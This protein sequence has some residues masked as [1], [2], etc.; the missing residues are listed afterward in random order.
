MAKERGAF[1]QLLI[2]ITLKTLACCRTYMT[3]TLCTHL[4]LH[5]VRI[6]SCFIIFVLPFSTVALA[7]SRLILI[8][9]MSDHRS[10]L[11]SYRSA[12]LSVESS[13]ARPP[14]T[15]STSSSTASQWPYLE[16]KI[17]YFVMFYVSP[18][19]MLICC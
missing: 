11:G 8:G 13:A 3:S 4:A 17:I 16:P 14:I 6:P 2:T 10:V 5:F 15:Y 9:A 18:V 1:L 19:L 7:S 12:V